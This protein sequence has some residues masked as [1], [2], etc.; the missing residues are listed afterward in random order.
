MLYEVITETAGATIRLEYFVNP[1]MSVQY[2]GSP[3]FSVGNYEK[4]KAV[5]DPG[6]TKYANRFSDV[7]PEPFEGDYIADIGD[8]RIRF[9]NPGFGFSQFRSNL[10]YRW[11]YTKGSHLY[12]IW[13]GEA[14]HF[15]AGDGNSLKS[16]INTLS[17][18]TFNSTFLIKRS[19]WLSI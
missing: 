19:Y 2:Y 18:S 9:A 5:V 6:A 8:D 13:A 1:M 14:T 4:Y 17:A 16:T 15:N 12:F 10:V 7:N 3:Y 11:E